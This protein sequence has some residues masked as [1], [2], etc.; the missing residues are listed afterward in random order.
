M[1]D[2]TKAASSAPVEISYAVPE[3]GEITRAEL[4]WLARLIAINAFQFISGDR[5]RHWCIGEVDRIGDVGSMTLLAFVEA[6][7]KVNRPTVDATA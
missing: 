2:A 7:S 4:D 1:S 3:K 5:D 6:A